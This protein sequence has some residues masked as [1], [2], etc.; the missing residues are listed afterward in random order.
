MS[1]YY[2][3]IRS[4]YHYSYW[5]VTGYNVVEVWIYEKNPI[6][7][8]LDFERVKIIATKYTV[9]DL[10]LMQTKDKVDKDAFDVVYNAAL[11]FI[12]SHF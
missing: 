9:Q 12:N 5:R 2:Y 3:Q 11:S 10:V 4:E 6:P 7:A 8:K 1:Q